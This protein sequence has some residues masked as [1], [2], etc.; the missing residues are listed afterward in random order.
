MVRIRL[1]R[2]LL[3]ALGIPDIDYPVPIDALKELSEPNALM[4]PEQLLAWLIN[5]PS[6]AMEVIGREDQAKIALSGL[7]TDHDD[8]DEIWVHGDE[9]GVILGQVDINAELIS[10]N[11]QNRII[12]LIQENDLHTLKMSCFYPLT[13]Q[14]ANMILEYLVPVPV[15]EHNLN[16]TKWKL[17]IKH[18]GSTMDA[19]QAKAGKPYHGY[20]PWGLGKYEDGGVDEDIIPYLNM[21]FLKAAQVAV[22]L[23]IFY[24]NA[25]HVNLGHVPP[26]SAELVMR[27]NSVYS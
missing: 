16:G 24:Q 1:K 9:W 3:D 21:P 5:H 26:E 19:Y 7:I 22:Q 13:A 8:R 6:D 18:S 17:A 4:H 27:L 20:W 11:H 2:E 14:T 10:I 15:N 25:A 12:A 23:G